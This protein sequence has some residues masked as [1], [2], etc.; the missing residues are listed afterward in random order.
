[1]EHLE[2]HESTNYPIGLSVEDN[3]VSLGITA[4]AIQPFNSE[5]IC[6]YMQQA[7]EN[8]AHTLDLPE[9]SRVCALDVVPADEIKLLTQTWNMTQ[10]AQTEG[11]CIHQLFEQQVERAPEAISLVFEGESLTYGELNTCANF[12][13][14]NLVERGVRPDSLVAICVERSVAMI[15]SILA[16]LKAGG[17]YVPLDPAYASDRLR[18]IL[19]DAAPAVLLVDNVGKKALGDESL[20]GIVCIDPNVQERRQADN[21]HI[22]GLMT[23]H[24]AYV[25]YTSGSTGK[26]KGVLIEHRGAVNLVCN[27]VDMFEIG[28][29]SRL[30]QFTSISFDNSVSEIFSAFKS[31]AS[32]Y[33]V[34]DDVRMDRDRLW[35]FMAANAISYISCTPTMLQ[36]CE[37]MPVLESLRT[38]IVM[39]EA[40][41]ITLPKA[42]KTI[43]PNCTIVNAYGP[44]ETT[45]GALAWKY[46]P[47]LEGVIAPIG[48]PNANTRIYILD[49]Y[50]RPVPLGV[51]G[52]LYIGGVGVA[53]GYLNRPDLT[54]ERFVTDPFVED[55]EARM[56][57]TGDLV[58]YLPD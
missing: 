17:A 30:L 56:Y 9:P 1:M 5:R 29:M 25:I 4:Q 8:L 51:V 54:A 12:L 24:L 57:K 21:P 13:A 23:S 28:P 55:P 27:E 48:R 22:V 3:G 46:S 43:A 35:K 58:S 31:G 49:A 2:S 32:L 37:E 18:D 20:S 38:V 11:L 42:V 10:D 34:Q 36:G 16:V 15:V 53:R 7:L 41:P 39:G 6:G 26:P 47:C 19:D 40:M 33:L 52:E 44:T 14:H 50:G 45:I